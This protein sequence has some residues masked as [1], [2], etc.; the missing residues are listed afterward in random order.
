[1]TFTPRTVRIAGA[2]VIAVLLVGVSYVL[3]GPSFLSS[4][5][6]GAEST[7]ELLTAYA[8]KDTDADGLPDWQ[9]SLY[10]TDPAKSDTDGDGI[11]DGEA[12]AQGLL[13]TQKLLTDTSQKPISVD[14]I[15]G[16]LAKPGTLTD[17]FS[18]IFF[19]RYMQNWNGEPLS[20]ADQKA[21]LTN[22][23]GEFTARA[24]KLLNSNYTGVVVRKSA[25]VTV[26]QYAGAVE[27]VIQTNEVA[28]G[29]GSP[30]E[31]A[32]KFVE[33]NDRG[34]LLKLKSLATA[35]RKIS[36]GLIATQVPYELAD[37]HLELIRAFDTLSRSTDV[38]SKYEEDPLAV[39]GA[40]ALLQPT[41]K[42]ILASF[43]Q[44]SDEIRKSG[45]PA[46]G[47]PGSMILEFVRT[48]N[49]S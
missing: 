36:D 47:Q 46:P 6:V 7:D 33:D 20:D 23:F 49:G 37:T 32:N 19:E 28:E 29:A 9:E 14:D 2:L 39:L 22:L 27:R 25:D 31:L 48:S 18:K 17:E 4:Q 10:G 26:L 35:Y 12:A 21:L 11:K 1:M 5:I 3:S 24:Q 15:P 42:A 44:I 41:S 43:A 13:S 34:A 16:P 45:T 8:A 40:L 38:L 30:I